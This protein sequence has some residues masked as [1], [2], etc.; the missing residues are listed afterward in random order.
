MDGAKLKK[1]RLK[2]GY[3]LG[4]LSEMTGISKSYLS[5]IERDIQK[6]PSLEILEKIAKLFEVD[7]EYLV[8]NKKRNEKLQNEKPMVRSILKVEIEISEDD[9]DPQKLKQIQK[10]LRVFNN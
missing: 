9:L 1:M 4:T 3:S 2:R 6:N 8:N 10:I 5:L 7:V